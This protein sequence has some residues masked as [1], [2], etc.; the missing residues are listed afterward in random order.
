VA[1]PKFRPTLPISLLLKH[2]I[3]VQSPSCELED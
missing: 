2:L 1:E 3:S